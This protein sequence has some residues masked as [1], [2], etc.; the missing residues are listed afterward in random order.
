M[1]KATGTDLDTSESDL[2]TRLR[3]SDTDLD[4]S[5]SDLDTRLRQ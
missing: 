5:E 4:T 2:D 3:H 1:P